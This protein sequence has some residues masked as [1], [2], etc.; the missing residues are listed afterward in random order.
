V[1]RKHFAY[2]SSRR[3]CV[4]FFLIRCSALSTA[5]GSLP[6]AAAIWL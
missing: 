5:F 6:S 2:S 1:P 4:S 3:T